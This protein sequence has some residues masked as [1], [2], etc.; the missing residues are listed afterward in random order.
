MS[1]DA[2]SRSREIILALAR[3]NFWSIQDW[4]DAVVERDL[5]LRAKRREL[6]QVDEVLHELADLLTRRL[7]E[8][9][10]QDPELSVGI[11]YRR[12]AT[13]AG[14]TVREVLKEAFRKYDT[15]DHS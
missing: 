7:I 11:P 13:E 1:E 5:E 2:N 12:M 3:S 6:E 14:E 4:A 9:W 15:S 10:S 8:R